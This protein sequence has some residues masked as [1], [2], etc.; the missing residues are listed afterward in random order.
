MNTTKKVAK[1][2]I[3]ELFGEWFYYRCEF[4]AVICVQKGNSNSRSSALRGAK[5][6]CKTIGYEME[7]TK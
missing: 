4:S 5:W 3:I 7:L 6:F 2:R 1:V